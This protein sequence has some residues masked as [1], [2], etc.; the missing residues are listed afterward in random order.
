VPQGLLANRQVHVLTSSAPSAP[1]RRIH[2]LVKLRSLLRGNDY[3]V[4]LAFGPSP[5]ALVS[6]ARTRSTLTVLSENGNPFVPGRKRWNATMMW[7]YRRADALIVYTRDLANDLRALRVVPRT[8]AICRV[9]LDAAI[10]LVPPSAPRT[11]T[12]VTVGRL[13]RSKRVDDL[14]AAFASLA[15][16]FP[17]WK[18]VI[19]GDGHER[20]ALEKDVAARGLT[21]RVTFSGFLDRPWQPLATASIFVLCSANEGFGNVLIEAAASGCAVISS[22]CRYGPREVLDDGELGLLYPVGDVSSLTG[23]L[24]RLMDDAAARQRLAERMFASI[25]RYRV[26]TS[27][28]P[29]MDLLAELAERRRT[30][31]T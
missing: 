23:C 7:T 26:D 30:A 18:L 3:D 28:D 10:P 6:L 4:A 2:Q 31:P 21:D 17:T 19:V 13:V 22:N 12:I 15:E 5:N 11:H 9:I 14:I 29:W 20:A 1:L 24:T 25:G 16:R 8:V 27:E